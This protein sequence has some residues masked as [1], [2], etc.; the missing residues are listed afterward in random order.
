MVGSFYSQIYAHI[1]PLGA[2]IDLKRGLKV[3][4]DLIL[5][6]QKEILRVYYTK[7]QFHGKVVALDDDGAWHLIVDHTKNRWI[8]KLIDKQLGEAWM[9]KWDDLARNRSLL[10]FIIKPF[11]IAFLF[12]LSLLSIRFSGV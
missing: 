6:V 3:R 8:F 2:L 4:S 11:V 5:T 10:L 7:L 9:L 12:R 1:S